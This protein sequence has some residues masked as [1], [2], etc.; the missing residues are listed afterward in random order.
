MAT[1]NLRVIPSAKQ[2]KILQEENRLKVYLRA[3]AAEGRANKA[4]ISALAQFYKAKKSSISIIKG[5]NSR[6]KVVDLQP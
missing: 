2:D 5:I 6:D 3:P 1:I 4:L